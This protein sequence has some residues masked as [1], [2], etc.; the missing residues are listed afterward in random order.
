MNTPHPVQALRSIGRAE[1]LRATAL[2]L[3]ALLVVVLLVIALD[4][5]TPNP[6][7]TAAPAPARHATTAQAAKAKAAPRPLA[8]P[9]ALGVYAGPAAPVAATVFQTDAGS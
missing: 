9:V 4:H 6:T 2:F 5:G 3:S 1:L 7:G 8:S